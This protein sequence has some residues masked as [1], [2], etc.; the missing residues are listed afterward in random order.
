LALVGSIVIYVRNLSTIN[1]TGPAA[2][3]PEAR[4]LRQ[5]V[6]PVLRYPAEEAHATALALQAGGLDVVELTMTTPGVFEV[7]RSLT[8]QGMVVGIGTITEIDSVREA[9]EV[10]ASFAV[11]Y[12]RP[13]GL[14]AAA[15]A[16]G[17]LAIPGALTPQECFEARTDGARWIK[18]FSARLGGPDYIRDL[19][20]VLPGVRFMV[21]G[22][23]G[24]SDAA[25]RPWFEAGAELIAVGE[26]LGTV[27]T[28]GAAEVTAR[29]RAVLAA[30]A[31]IP[32]GGDD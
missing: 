17:I 32:G 19:R 20:P 14:V 16:A 4:A 28:F 2:Q 24:T 6:V 31:A 1:E 5:R 7:A 21:S 22:G 30:C 25:L 27:G 8:A 23:I 13:P 15:A 18:I 11:S 9:A 10:G 3:G 12:C 29:A 26:D